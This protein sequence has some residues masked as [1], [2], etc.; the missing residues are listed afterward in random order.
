MSCGWRRGLL[1]GQCRSPRGGDS[2]PPGSALPRT[3]LAAAPGTRSPR[4]HAEPLAP[5]LFAAP[6]S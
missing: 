4:I 3:V 6:A 2:A 5:R 1:G